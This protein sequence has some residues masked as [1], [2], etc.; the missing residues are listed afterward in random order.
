MRSPIIGILALA[1]LASGV[2][3][4]TS[5][6]PA[7]KAAGVERV[8]CDA[9]ATNDAE[10]LLRSTTVL[11]SDAIY[12][13]VITG[14]NNSED[15]VAGAKLLVR[16]P[17]GVTAELM[18]RTLQ[19]VRDDEQ[20][21]L[22]DRV[23]I[24]RMSEPPMT[25]MASGFCVCEPMPFESRREEAEH[26]HERRHQHGAEALLGGL[27]RG[28]LDGVPSVSRS[29]WKYVTTRIASWMAMPKIEMKPIAADTEKLCP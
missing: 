25:T 26:R 27:A 5:T 19:C 20:R 24:A 28:L 17:E 2:G 12:T 29:R 11:R 23:R 15:R 3:C 1:A 21:R 9:A 18:V 22:H 14:N 7:A 8:Q 4:A 10:R 16:P 6:P 13:H